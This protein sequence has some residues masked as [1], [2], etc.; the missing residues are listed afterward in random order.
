MR[1]LIPIAALVSGLTV[2]AP[3]AI[4]AAQLP[5]PV[6]CNGCWQPAAKTTWQWQLQGRIDLS[7]PA[8]MYDVDLFDTPRATVRALHHRGR[9]AVCY[10]DA[11]TWEN[12]R[13]DAADF[14]KRVRGRT[15]GWPGERWLDIRRLAVLAPIM[16]ARLDRCVH[17]GFDGVEFDNV[18]GYA[19]KTGFPLT[20][21]DQLRYDA[22]L[23]NAAHRRGL[24]AAL[25]NDLGQIPKLLPYFDYALDEQ[26]FQYHECDNL[27][28]FVQDG[29]AV[30]TV[31]YRSQPAD[32]CPKAESLGFSSIL[33]APNFSLYDEPY[34]PC[35]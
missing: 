4:A 25:K 19:N 11:G 15:N 17:R 20:G 16:R 13:P 9:H 35:R 26:C 33:K 28:P 2:Y 10:L 6:Q 27:V 8:A 23:A 1:R 29:K 18:G 7:V 24:S 21:A 32:F 31:E 30:F 12:W 22:W 14:P 3:P 34:T 5:K